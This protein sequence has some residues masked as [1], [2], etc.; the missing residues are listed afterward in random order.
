MAEATIK[1]NEGKVVPIHVNTIGELKSGIRLVKITQDYQEV[2]ISGPEEV[3]NSID[4]IETENID[5]SNITDS[6]NIKVS[7]LIPNNVQVNLG[8]LNSITVTINVEKEDSKELSIPVTFEGIGEG[9]SLDGDSK[10]VKVKVSGYADEIKDINESSIVA[11]IDLSKYTEA[12]EYTEAPVVSLVT[13]N[14][15]VKL[16]CSDKVTFTL[17]KVEETPTE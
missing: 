7:L 12:G 11:K 2:E 8:Q 6:T 17:L 10:V 1:I 16:E 15:K 5:L 9:F 14:D 13:P 3:L 4:T